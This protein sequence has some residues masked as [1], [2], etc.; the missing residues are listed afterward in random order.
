MDNK[1]FGIYLKKL[2]N[3]LGL[4][5]RDV[6]KLADVSNA[7]LSMVE[8]GKRGIPKPEFLK[9]ISG[10]YN[11]SIEELME[12]AG[13]IEHPATINTFKIDGVELPKELV[14]LGVEYLTV[15]RELKEQGLSPDDI[16]AIVRV[17]QNM[18]SSSKQ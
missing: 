15:T 2:R 18:K 4:R 7:H 9:K 14:D 11:V 3:D 12:K 8:Q 16:R 6:E 13:Y 1:E 10:V 5:I 17:V